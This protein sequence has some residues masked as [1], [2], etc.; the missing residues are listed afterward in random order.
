MHSHQPTLRRASLALVLC[1]TAPLVELACISENEGDEDSDLIGGRLAKE[2]EFPAT[3]LMQGSCTAAKVG[4]R[5]ILTAAHCIK[6]QQRGSIIT[7]TNRKNTGTFGTGDGDSFRRFTLAS[8]AIEPAWLARCGG[9]FCGSVENGGRN[10]MGDAAILTVTEDIT[11]IPEAAVDLSPIKTDDKVV[12]TGYGCEEKVGGSWSYDGSRLKLA[13]V[14]VLPFESTIHPGSFIRE[15]DRTSG[16]LQTMGDL[17]AI[18][19]GPDAYKLLNTADAGAAIDAGD[20]GQTR[21]RRDAGAGA[22]GGNGGLCPGDSGG[23]LYRNDR[24]GLTVVGVNSNYTFSSGDSST[25]ARPGGFDYG[26]SPVTN[27]HTK[28][29]SKNSLRIG[30]WLTSLGVKTTCTRGGC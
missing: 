4:P 8:V 7:I 21:Q 19:P 2:D 11:G 15:A 16:L 30:T 12:V 27:W 28:L 22:N 26:G 18:T 5:H 20:A 24:K 29:D 1:L 6:D 25:G 14:K 9:G 23:P 3:L 13:F 10:K 17:Y